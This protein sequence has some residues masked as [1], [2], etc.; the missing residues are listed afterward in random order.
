MAHNAPQGPDVGFLPA[1]TSMFAVSAEET[2]KADSMARLTKLRKAYNQ[3]LGHKNRK[4]SLLEEMTRSIAAREDQDMHIAQ[5]VS[6]GER[7]MDALEIRLKRM[8]VE[9][10]A[11][12]ALGDFYKR[13]IF[14]AGDTKNPSCEKLKLQEMEQQVGLSRL[15]VKDLLQKRQGLYLEKEHID[16]VEI[17][18][19]K[20]K[21][22]ECNGLLT[23]DRVRKCERFFERA[24]AASI[25]LH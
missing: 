21:R 14:H 6:V 16:K 10:R 15:Q 7:T 24:G 17:R 2:R 20:Q 9:L 5:T 11:S 4:K 23:Y 12:E 13:I 1:H 3:I 19:I 22:R 8:Q 18:E 25:D